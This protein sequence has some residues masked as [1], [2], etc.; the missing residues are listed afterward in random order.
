ILKRAGFRVLR[1]ADGQA[2]MQIV[3]TEPRV[4]LVLLDASMPVM[5]GPETILAL[6]DDGW[7][8][9]VVVMSGHAMEEATA[10]FATWGASG[11]VQKP[12][13]RSDLVS[14]VLAKLMTPG[15]PA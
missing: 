9:P 1:A 13:R 11:F 12:F 15:G 6:R 4:D 7:V 3:R 5:G 14:T 8:G 2:A 10:Q